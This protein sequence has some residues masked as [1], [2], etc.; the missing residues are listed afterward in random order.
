MAVGR[1]N[2]P[3]ATRRLLR[4]LRATPPPYQV[5]VGSGLVQRA[6]WLNTDIGPHARYWLDMGRPFPFPDAS[7]SRLFS[8]HVVEHVTP[9]IVHR[10]LREAYRVLTPDGILRLLTPDAE[11]HAREY[12][13][14]S[15]LADA[16][17]QRA[18]RL[19]YYS[20]FPVDILNLTFHAN[21]HRYIW[22]EASLRAALQAA[23]FT[24]VERR[25]VGDSQDPAL[26]AMDGH[27]APDDPAIPM[28]LVLEARR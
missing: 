24:R 8:E 26:A 19:G 7:V 22:D 27:F 13:A 10:F 5:Q 12:L 15:P 23:G 11:A 6:G 18:A 28:T 14:R 25:A 20:R 16:L 21:G 2:Q 4:Y 9:D 1:A 3:L 17:V